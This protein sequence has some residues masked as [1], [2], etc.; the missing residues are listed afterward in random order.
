MTTTATF[1][2]GRTSVK[3]MSMSSFWS[4]S[5]TLKSTRTRFSEKGRPLTTASWALRTLAA[6]TSFMAS[7]IFLVFFT[8]VDSG[9][10]WPSGS[11]S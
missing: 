6:A 10:A 11:M 2:T 1:F 5:F 3:G 9:H 4:C 7:V 8:D